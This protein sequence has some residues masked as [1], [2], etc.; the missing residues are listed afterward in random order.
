MALELLGVSDL[1]SLDDISGRD[2]LFRFVDL[3]R[4]HYGA[5]HVVYHS[6]RFPGHTLYDPYLFLTYSQ[7][8]IQRYRE[9]DYL[10]LDPII[11]KSYRAVLPIDWAE[12]DRTDNH[13][14]DFFGESAE[15]GVGRQGLSIPVR[16]PDGFVALFTASFDANDREWQKLRGP[17]SRDLFLLGHYFHSKVIEVEFGP[18]PEDAVEHLTS[19]EKQCLAWS[20]EGKTIEDVADILGISPTTVR[21]YVD[22]ARHKLGALNKVHAIARAI[23]LGI[24]P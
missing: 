3:L 18:S 8:W 2:D 24:I 11:R 12:I 21:M 5:A 4:E 23:R 19:R 17:A 16:G 13:V 1:K 20:A 15:F 6:Q 7:D 22:S 10:S 14:R 9:R